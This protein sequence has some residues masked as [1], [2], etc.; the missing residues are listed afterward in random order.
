LANGQGE[1]YLT[2]T[3]GRRQFLLYQSGCIWQL[4]VGNKQAMKEKDFN[5]FVLV[6]VHEVDDH[7]KHG[8]WTIMRCCD[9]PA[10]SKTIMSI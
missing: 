7:E 9:M 6:M 8:H 1:S 5:D 10:D 3:Y 4:E 2:V